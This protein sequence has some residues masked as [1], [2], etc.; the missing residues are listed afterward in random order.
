MKFS[1]RV[2]VVFLICVT[3]TSAQS[4]LTGGTRPAKFTGPLPV[5]ASSYPLMAA[6][7]T[8]G[9]PDLAKLGYVE[10]EFLI[11]G[12]ANVYDW[13]ADGS[14]KVLAPNGSYTTRILVRRPA[15]QA[16]FSGN[17]IVETMNNARR[18]DWAMLFG[19]IHNE[20]FEHGDAWIGVTMPGTGLAG[21]QKFNPT[22]YPG[23]AF[24]NPTPNAPCPGGAANTASD[25]EEG[26]KWDMLSQLGAL[27]KSNVASR[28]LAS[29]RVQKVYMT[30]QNVDIVTYINAI[31]P[32]VTLDNGGPV[33]D[34]Y[35]VKSPLAPAKI[36]RCAV[37]P[38]KGDPRATL[39]KINVPVIAVASQ[40]EVLNTSAFRRPDGDTL[41]DQFRLYEV[42]GASHID[43]SPYYSLLNYDDQAAA[44]GNVQGNPAWPFA[45]KCMPDIPLT[46]LPL[47]SYVFDAALYNLDQWVRKG[48]APPH[49]MPIELKNAGA[50][51]ASV[52]MDQYG[53]GVGGVRS[54]YVDV[55]SAT[56]VT[57]TVGAGTCPELGHKT[58]WD[59]A[60]FNALYGSTANYAAKVAR[61]VDAL[62][63]QHW[64]T[65]SDGKRI[66][67]EAA[68]FRP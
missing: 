4:P 8:S 31:H 38:V 15:N 47:M 7:R 13:A 39:Q 53:H 43:K 27:L 19:Y 1:I 41:G 17:V 59:A 32:H 12:T 2:L 58:A 60:R 63:K 46:E 29:L 34:G 40:G 18:F 48:T 61:S 11:S 52:L 16:K 10:E 66:K 20:L 6:N 25:S 37:A 9:A 44:G 50:A 3:L 21:L 56:Y 67:A 33:Y 62:V 26:L 5:T 65:D 35:L 24:T 54:P 51:D 64:F 30:T 14:L 42:A 68:A 36:N 57:N 55:P 49:G 45:A 23:V 28:P 22:R